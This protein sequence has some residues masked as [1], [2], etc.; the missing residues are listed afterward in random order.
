MDPKQRSEL[1]ELYFHMGLS[2]SEILAMLVFKHNIVISSR[3]LKRILRSC[4]L[5]RRKY[6][7]NLYDVMRYI[8][9]ELT[10]SGRLHV[11]KW[12]H[13][14]CIQQ[15][16]VVK[17]QTV[18]HILLDLDPVGVMLRKKHRL[19][20]RLYRCGGPNRVWHI[21]SYDKLKPFGICINGC[22]DGYSRHMLWLR[23]SS[24][25]SDPKVIAGYF[26]ETVE[27]LSGCPLTVR[28]DM[29]TENGHI[30]QMQRFF[31]RND[32]DNTN[33]FIYGR[34]TA[35]QRIE[36]WWGILRTENAQYWMDLF[37]KIK[38]DGYFSG[39]DLDKGLIQF[40]FLKI[41]QVI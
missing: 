12:L 4:N 28:T 21:D 27:S 5:Y 1:I 17:Q 18:R 41:I 22:I 30:F 15:G 40:C 20:R 37:N 24:T 32:N 10:H 33:S 6:Y 14:K 26:V 31:R 3:H 2:Q 11:Y 25:N 36:R 13:K 16:L 8:E 9:K 7:S 34:S 38:D 23:A 35:N 19:R 29:G 39:D